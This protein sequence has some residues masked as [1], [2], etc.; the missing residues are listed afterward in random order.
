LPGVLH[1]LL[2]VA[3]KLP[4]LDEVVSSRGQPLGEKYAIVVIECLTSSKSE[5]RAAAS[6]LL[7]TSVE[8]GIV[9][10]ESIRKATECLKPAKQRS[11][12]SLVARISKSVPGA[13]HPEKENLLGDKSS[14]SANDKESTSLDSGSRIQNTK[15]ASTNQTCSPERKKQT[16]SSATKEPETA[17]PSS[18][19]HPLVLRTRKRVARSSRS[20]NW[21]EF[22]EEPYG[23]ILEDLK[24]YWAPFLPPA[25]VSA[26]F[27]AGGVKQQ[28]DAKEGCKVLSRALSADRSSGCSV[29]QGQLDLILKWITFALYSKETTTGLP[30]ILSVLIDTLKYMVEI[31][32]ELSDAEALEIVP[33]LLE[34]VSGAKVGAS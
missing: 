15:Q 10:M 16:N 29:V 34:K 23:S 8:N 1:L 4:N 13:S 33:F 30:D 11:I 19:K 17:S 22:P 28:D 9:S 7:N 25:T 6:S 18:P 21:T 27:P 5:T 12:G 3:D 32:H 20:V 14:A 24:R 26:L 2:T 31:N